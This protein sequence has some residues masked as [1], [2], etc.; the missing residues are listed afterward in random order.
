MTREEMFE[1]YDEGWAISHP[2]VEKYKMSSEKVGYFY[3][4]WGIAFETY[5][6][7]GFD[8]KAVPVTPWEIFY[9]HHF[10]DMVMNEKDGYYLVGDKPYNLP[11]H[12]RDL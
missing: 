10:I 6:A 8:A 5:T 7:M 1:K 12:K 9:K 3:K 4:A 11:P 2:R